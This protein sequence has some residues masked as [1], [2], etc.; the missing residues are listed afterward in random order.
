MINRGRRHPYAKVGEFFHR[1]RWY[2]FQPDD[3]TLELTIDLPR[4][5]S[6]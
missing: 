2:G 4:S 6:W 5:K 1:V 3:D